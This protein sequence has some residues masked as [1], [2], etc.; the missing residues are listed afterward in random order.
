MPWYVLD[1]GSRV[2]LDKREGAAIKVSLYL[3]VEK[4][5]PCFLAGERTILKILLKFA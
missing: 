5:K 3:L 4:M 1:E 2:P